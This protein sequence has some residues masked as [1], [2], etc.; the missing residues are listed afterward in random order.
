MLGLKIFV[1]GADDT[2]RERKILSEKLRNDIEEVYPESTVFIHFDDYLN[3]PPSKN[4][5]IEESLERV[6]KSDAL[7]AVLKK[8]F[9]SV[10]KNEI[11]EAIRVVE[12]GEIYEIWVFYL[13]PESLKGN[14][15][16]KLSE[17]IDN[18]KSSKKL[19]VKEYNTEGDFVRSVTTAIHGFILKKLGIPKDIKAEIAGSLSQ[20]DEIELS[21][22]TA[23]T[24]GAG[25]IDDIDED[26][27]HAEDDNLQKLLKE[28]QALEDEE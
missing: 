15:E 13:N 8:K 20:L 17:F 19:T 5:P 3:W 4:N 1:S 11:E 9:G 25:I 16:P 6:G 21:P 26:I 24:A 18:L 23:T 27:R 2:L 12:S 7:L 22:Y 14:P 28:R 10:T